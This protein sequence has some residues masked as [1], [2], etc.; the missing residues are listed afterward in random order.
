LACSRISLEITVSGTGFFFISS[1]QNKATGQIVQIIVAVEL[2]R[3]PSI[4][5]IDL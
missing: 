1:S 3:A 2:R 5:R 4:S